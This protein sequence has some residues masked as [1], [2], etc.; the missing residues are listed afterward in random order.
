MWGGL[1]CD[2]NLIE[3]ER[4]PY[5]LALSHTTT[6]PTLAPQFESYYK[7]PRVL[8]WPIT[9]KEILL[10]CVVNYPDTVGSITQVHQHGA[11]KK[12]LNMIKQLAN[13][14]VV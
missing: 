11:P 13:S 9:N 14:E 8:A 7:H 12:H 1:Q 4:K 5:V 6:G 10:Q 3:T 2:L